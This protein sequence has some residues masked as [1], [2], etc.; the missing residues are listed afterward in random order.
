MAPIPDSENRMTARWLAALAALPLAVLAELPVFPAKNV[1]ETFFGTRVDDPY[2]ALESEKDPAVA[3]WMKAHADHAQKTLESLKGYPALRARLAELDSAAA[4]R[5]GAVARMPVATFFTRRGATENVFK[6][7]VRAADGAE[8]LLVDPETFQK[9]TGKPHAINYFEPSPDSKWVAVGISAGGNEL[10]SLYIIDAMTGK[11]VGEPID[12]ARYSQPQWLPDSKAL[13]YSRVPKIAPDAPTSELFKNRRTY[14][15]RVGTNP[16]TDVYLLGPDGNPKVPVVPTQGTVIFYEPGS[17]YAVA[18]VY[19]GVRREL[20]LYSAPLDVAMRAD[21]E[22]RK[23][24]DFDDK[25]TGF[26]VH[27]SDIYLLTHVG[28]PRFS[29]RRTS[30]ASPDVRKAEVVVPDGAE[31]IGR[32]AGARDALYFETREGALKRLKR[33]AWGTKQVVEVP[34]P[35]QGAATIFSTRATVDGAVVGVTAWTRALEIYDVDRNGKATNTGLQPLGRFDAPTDLVATEVRVRSHDGAMVPLSIV[36]KKGLKLDGSNPA[37]LVGYGSYGITFD[38]TF[39]PIR[40][41][42]L[43]QGAVYAV[44]NVRGSSAYGEDW[45]K[46][47]YKETKPNTW[48]DFIACAEYL[49]ANKYTS[50]KKLAISG[51]SAGGITVGRALTERPD[52]FAAA[53]P[54]VGMLDFVRLHVMPIGPVNVPEFGDIREEAGFRALLAMSSYH[55]VK[56]GTRYPA[57]LFQHG[58]NDTRVNVGQSNKMAARLM[59]A[60]ASGKPILLDLDYDSGHGQGITKAQRQKLLAN[61]YSFV[62]WQAGH[63]GFQPAP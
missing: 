24:C 62:L 17:N 53:I 33:V 10:A 49:I 36:H 1:P 59:A 25:V 26:A 51:G 19:D 57:V 61:V 29:I 44:A 52:L 37:L 28:S 55:H 20:S 2:R 27:G 63:P 50:N 16:E 5:V 31:V 45:Y 48:K 58:V 35:V 21:A 46:A 8:K 60:S 38:A 7:Y 4:A 42:L 11:R 34:L 3:A 43:E 15:H 39:D 14:L 56:D 13:F 23:I 47:G 9:E 18:E 22:W 12:R 54:Q 30:L 41:A 6:L 40:L 32:I